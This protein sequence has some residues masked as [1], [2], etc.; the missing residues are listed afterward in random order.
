MV[1]A[2]TGGGPE[3]WGNPGHLVLLSGQS[4]CWY[5]HSSV[6]DDYKAHQELLKRMNQNLNLKVEEIDDSVLASVDILTSPRSTRGAVPLNEAILKP[7]KALWQT[8]LSLQS[9]VKQVERK[10]FIPPKG[11]E[12]LYTLPPPGSLVMA[13]VND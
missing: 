3:P 10:Y 2:T 1:P 8:P 13:T 9:T 5:I 4:H 12:Y 11:Y 7:I 6:Q